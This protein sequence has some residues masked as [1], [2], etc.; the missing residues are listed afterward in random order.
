MIVSEREAKHLQGRLHIASKMAIAGL[1]TPARVTLERLE[2]PGRQARL[3]VVL[4]VTDEELADALSV[5]PPPDPHA[6]E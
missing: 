1:V 4:R 2:L 5:D 6:D 3:V